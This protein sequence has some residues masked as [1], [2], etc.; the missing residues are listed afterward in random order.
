MAFLPFHFQSKFGSIRSLIPREWSEQEG[1]YLKPAFSSPA[2][3]VDQWCKAKGFLTFQSGVILLNFCIIIAL[4]GLA[5]LVMSWTPQRTTQS[6]DEEEGHELQNVAPP[7]QPVPLARPAGQEQ[8]VTPSIGDQHEAQN[9][10][11]PQRSPFDDANAIVRP[12]RP[13]QALQQPNRN[14]FDDSNEIGAPRRDAPPTYHSTVHDSISN[15]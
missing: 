5:G 10:S 13:A 3:L 15:L 12:Q 9:T 6:T 8:S 11:F 7:A 4:F 2:M 1:R 14:P